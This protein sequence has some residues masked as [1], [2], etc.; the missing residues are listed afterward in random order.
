MS[1]KAKEF[2]DLTSAQAILNTHNPVQAKSIGKRIK[3]YNTEVWQRTCNSYMSKGLAAKFTQNKDLYKFLKE[4]GNKL[5]IEANP[6]DCYWGVGLPLHDKDIWNP[7]K[8]KGKNELA[9]LLAQLP[10]KL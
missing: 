3:N 1:C 9:T 8:W 5:L 10:E 7:I 4:M 6:R 2:N